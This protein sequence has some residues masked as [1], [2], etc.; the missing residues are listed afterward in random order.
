MNRVFIRRVLF[1]SLLKPISNRGT[2][3]RL[4]CALAVPPYGHSPPPFAARRRVR[5]STS[6]AHHRFARLADK[7]DLGRWSACREGWRTARSVVPSSHND[8]HG[9]VLHQSR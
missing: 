6:M 5:S 8:V 9:S 3:F 4:G 1:Q 7:A 2:G